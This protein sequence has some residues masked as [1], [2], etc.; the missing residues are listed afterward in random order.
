MDITYILITN[1]NNNNNLLFDI[2]YKSTD[3]D[4][5]IF[6]LKKSEGLLTEKNRIHEG[7]LKR[8]WQQGLY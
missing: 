8:W 4:I 7:K 2:G 5:N 1:N 3:S 6:N